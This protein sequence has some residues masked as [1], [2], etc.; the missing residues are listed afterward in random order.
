[1][2][3]CREFQ[4]PHLLTATPCSL[5]PIT[6][7]PHRLCVVEFIAVYYIT[8]LLCMLVDQRQL[9]R[10]HTY[11]VSIAHHVVL[12][13]PTFSTTTDYYAQ[14]CLFQLFLA[15]TSPVFALLLLASYSIDSAWLALPFGKF[16]FRHLII[17]PNVAMLLTTHCVAL[18]V[19]LLVITIGV[20]HPRVVCVLFLAFWSCA[21]KWHVQ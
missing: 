13:L 3:G 6:H 7:Q 10:H 4:P 18:P 17:L 8:H 12:D 20:L 11:Y 16:T 14:S 21:L 9:P 19:H 5:M 15:P 2:I 1:M